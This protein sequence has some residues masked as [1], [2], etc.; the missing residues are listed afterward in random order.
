M[1]LRSALRLVES[2][3]VPLTPPAAARVPQV[4]SPWSTGS[5][6][7][8]PWLDVFGD[9]ALPM[10]RDQALAVPAMGRARDLL[11]GTVADQPLRAYRGDQLVDPQPYALYRTDGD[12]SPWLRIV[13]TVDDLLFGGWS[14]WAV[15]RGA[16][17]FVSNATRVPPDWWGWDNDG[18]TVLVGPQEDRQP[19]T[20]GS[21]LLFDGGRSGLLYSGAQTLRAAMAMERSAARA[22]ANPV[23]AL[24]LHQLTDDQ[25]DD[26]EA[27]QLVADV[28]AAMTGGGVMFTNAAI[29]LRDHGVVPEQLMIAGRNA[30]SVAIAQLTGVPPSL[31]YANTAGASLTYETAVTR[32]AEFTDLVLRWY[33][34]PI[35][36]R[37]SM[38]DVVP[39]GQRVRFDLTNL[40]AIPPAPTGAV[41][42]D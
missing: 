39:R 16:D 24:E 5:L 31:L 21:V 9:S 18:R 8:V 6:S 34:A 37:L 10:T 11:C 2:A 17:G 33:M 35:E 14:L 40:L 20:A 36:Q 42:E 23:P 38:D 29:E 30:S 13:G 41:T 28:Y 27:N 25:L 4:Q 26:A 7:F 32:N 19:V 12:V 15:D 3:S 1:G 22:S